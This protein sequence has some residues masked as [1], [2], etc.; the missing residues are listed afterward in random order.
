MKII[1][2]VGFKNSGKTTLIS[3]LVNTF[4]I[5]YGLKVGVLKHAH[6]SFDIDREGTDSHKIR[7][8]GSFETC[9]VSNKR[10]AFIKEEENI[11][12]DLNQLIS[13]FNSEILL[14]EGFKN[15]EWT[16]KIEVNLTQN[17]NEI[18]YHK[19]KNIKALVTNGNYQ[20]NIPIYR[21]DE[22]VEI[23]EYIL[24]L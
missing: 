11:D 13:Q 7:K 12:T 24:T 14:I 21:H 3:N 17:K 9:I 10:L 16:S 18:L 20:F 19:I 6:H 5:K 1:S 4:N 2:I 22:I 8:S 23:A 15:V